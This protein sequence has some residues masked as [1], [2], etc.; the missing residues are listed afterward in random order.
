MDPDPDQKLITAPDPNLQ[1]IS[2]RAGS[3]TLIPNRCFKKLQYVRY[4]SFLFVNV[5]VHIHVNIHVVN[6]IYKNRCKI[7]ALLT[8]T[9]VTEPNG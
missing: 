3:T 2:D 9:A 7:T 1:N 6:S 8:S 4:C 5:H